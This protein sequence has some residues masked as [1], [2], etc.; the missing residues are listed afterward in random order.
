MFAVETPI[1]LVSIEFRHTPGGTV[2]AVAI[3]NRLL[4]G[5]AGTYIPGDEYNK[6]KGRK[7]S[8]ADA[9]HSLPKEVRTIVWYGYW[10]NSRRR[11]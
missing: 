1:G 9:L 7:R 3:P 10:N 11:E 8:L 5:T 6:Y 4:I 2:C